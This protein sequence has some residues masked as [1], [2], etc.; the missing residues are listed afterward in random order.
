[1]KRKIN[2]SKK[3]AWRLLTFIVLVAGAVVVDSLHDQL[4]EQLVKN[5][6]DASEPQFD[7]SQVFFCNPASSFKIRTGCDRLFSKILFTIGQDKFLTAFHNQ[8]AFHLLKADALKVPLPQN[9]T[10]HFRKFMIC[11]HSSSDDNAPLS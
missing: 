2:I 10:V 6:Q 9:L 1:V 8:K 5:Q 11:H 4:P 3:I 7:I